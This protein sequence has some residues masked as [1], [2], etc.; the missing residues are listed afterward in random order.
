[1]KSAKNQDKTNFIVDEKRY[2]T[3]QFLAENFSTPWLNKI[4]ETVAFW[5]GNNDQLCVKTSGSTGVPKDIWLDKKVLAHSA[6]TTLETLQIKKNGTALLFL[7]CDFIG[8]K[9][10][11]FR[12]LVGELDLYLFE[13]KAALPTAIGKF[14]FV[15]LTPMQA[16]LSIAVLHNFKNILLGG[17]S[18]STELEDSLNQLKCGVFHSYGMTETASHVALRKINSHSK[19]ATYNALNG[20]LF[21]VDERNCLIINAPKWHVH[22]LITNDVVELVSNTCFVWKGRADNVINTGGV[23]VFPEELEKQLDQHINYPFFISNVPDKKTG[24]RI[25]LIVQS[26]MAVEIDFSFLPKSHQPKEVFFLPNFVLTKTGKLD[27]N[28]S[29]DLA[30]SRESYPNHQTLDE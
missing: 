18:V 23:K 7:P 21:S 2:S 15:A 9:M 30:I 5:F 25:I 1:M 13:P 29:K 17:G 27:R 16:A 20:V 8:G 28:K 14:D 12:A 22:N 11:V 24:S 3:H 10:M 26:E 4:Q 19:S 6:I